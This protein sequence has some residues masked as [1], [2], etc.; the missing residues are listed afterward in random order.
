M[1]RKFHL[2]YRLIIINIAVICAGG[3]LA[4]FLSSL[5]NALAASDNSH[6]ETRILN[7]IFS[8]RW[9]IFADMQKER[10]DPG[11]VAY[12]NKIYVMGGYFPSFFG[13]NQTQE[14]YDPLT[15]SWQFLANL[16]VERSDMM[17]APVGDRIYAI[18]GWNMD[19]GG[20]MTYT[21]EYNPLADNW[22]TR[23]SMITPVSGAGVVVLTDTVVPTS[24]IYILGGAGRSGSLGAVQKYDPIGDTWS[25]G[26]PMSV[27]RS[28]LGAV[29]LNGKVYAIG[30]VTN[31][32]VT[33]NT[34][35]IYYPI[36]DTWKMGP[37]LPAG[38]ASMAVGVRQGKIYVAS[39]TDD[40][41]V[42]SPTNTAFVFDPGTGMW[43]T[44]H[45][46]PT[47][48]TAC[49]AAVVNDIIYV[50]GGVGD[51]GAGSAN[52]GFGFPPVTSTVTI[53]SDNPDPSQIYQPFT[54]TY[55]VNASGEFP[56][57]VVTV[58]VDN[59]SESCHGMLSNGMGSCGL[60]INSLGTYS[61]TAT[62]GGDNILL[63]SSIT[64][65][66]SVIKADT[67]TTITAFD[68]EPSIIGQPV[69]INYA[70]TNPYGLPTGTVVITA[71]N[72]LASCSGAL[73]N[74]TGNCS[75]TL[76]TAGPY[77][78]TATYSGDDNFNPSN[79]S[80]SH[81]VSKID[82]TTTIVTDNPDPSLIN[83]P[84]SVTY[85]VTSSF[86]IPTGS[87]VITASN[88]PASCSG[89]LTNA[90]GN[91]SL[92]LNAAGPY[93]LTATYS[94]DDNHNPSNGSKS[95]SV[96]KIDTTTTIV[97]DNPDPSLIN[98]P[99]SVTYSVTSSFGIPTGPVTITVSN[100]N[101]TCSNNLINGSGDC[102]ITI[103][104]TGTYTLSAEYN[105]TATFNP[106]SDTEIHEV[107]PYRVYLP[108][109]RR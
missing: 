100:S 12:N 76:N 103:P 93:T 2:L 18:G 26:T 68:P 107:V 19:L 84:I 17:V 102:S 34:V 31:S 83:Q 96:S 44:V 23:T 48:R 59:R 21:Q 14:V 66:H 15:N 87:V 72:S 22:I 95:H 35:E 61:L 57:G 32:G 3:I 108:L 69:T 10:G 54:V 81:S 5:S 74:A 11:V 39:G 6:S 8:E 99:I 90:T 51:P 27:P 60:A 92:T 37:P 49:R 104:S 85:S 1:K 64:A 89:A 75:L 55:A 16:P 73:T 25:S 41:S 43:S 78:L 86:G 105:G 79:G 40:W 58:T 4:L 109:S 50:I 94:G 82:T 20:P 46:L 98:Q 28:E 67:N 29:L 91:C 106:S 71:S 45:V 52:E 42:G 62:Y 24:T 101:V 63:G 97:T 9:R 30:G 38:R 88:S 53:S 36:T 80:K 7:G 33:T 70:V 47:S 65:T 56:T 13:Y 77:T